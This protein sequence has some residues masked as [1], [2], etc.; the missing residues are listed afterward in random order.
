MNQKSHHTV[1]GA[2]QQSANIKYSIVYSYHRECHAE[3]GHYLVKADIFEKFCPYK[4]LWEQ[5]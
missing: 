5:Q 1:T 4:K 2:K 3:L